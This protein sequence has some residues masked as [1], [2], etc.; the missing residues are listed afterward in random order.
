VDSTMSSPAA[1][2][3]RILGQLG[4]ELRRVALTHAHADHVGG[5]AGV[6]RRFPTIEVSIGER[7]AR[8]LSGDKSLDPDEPQNPV[9]G[10]LRQ[11]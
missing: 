8:L 2:V 9:K 7:D 6:L 10:Y 1:E 11:G 4:L 5:V 3:A